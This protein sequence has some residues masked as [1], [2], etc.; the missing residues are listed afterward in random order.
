MYD[1]CRVK[2]CVDMCGEQ[3]GVHYSVKFVKEG[4]RSMGEAMWTGTE[5]CRGLGLGYNVVP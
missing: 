2:G 1:K 3:R 5:V 4:V